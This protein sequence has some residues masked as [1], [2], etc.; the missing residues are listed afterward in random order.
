MRR[1]HGGLAPGLLVLQA[2]QDYFA[3][4]ECNNENLNPKD[5]RNGRL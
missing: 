1:L 4:I 5:Y 2:Q 3:A